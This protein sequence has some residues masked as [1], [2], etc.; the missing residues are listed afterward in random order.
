M[1]VVT[2]LNNM[3]NKQNDNWLE[4]MKEVNPSKSS[5]EVKSSMDTR[6][7]FKISQSVKNRVKVLDRV[8]AKAKDKA[9]KLRG[10]RP[11]LNKSINEY[12]EQHNGDIN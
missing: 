9:D 7:P 1:E 12:M 3:S 6:K 4:K 5:R 2:H 11:S 8:L 10:V